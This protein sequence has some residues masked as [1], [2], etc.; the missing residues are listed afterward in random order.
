MERGQQ[1]MLINEESCYDGKVV[2]SKRYKAYD[3]ESGKDASVLESRMVC[4]R[5]NKCQPHEKEKI[6]SS[7]SSPNNHFTTKDLE[8]NKRERQKIRGTNQEFSRDDK[9]LKRAKG[10]R[11]RRLSV[12]GIGVGKKSPVKSIFKMGRS[13]VNE[14]ST[15]SRTNEFDSKGERGS[16]QFLGFPGQ[17]VSYPPGFDDFKEFCKA[18]GVI[19]GVKSTVERKKSLLVEVSENK[20]ELELVLGELGLSRKMRVESMPKEVANAQSI[21]SM[22]GDD[23]GPRQTSGD[24]VRTK[25]PRSGS[26]AQPNLTTSKIAHKFSKRQIKKV[27]LAS[28]TTVSG[29]VAQGKRRRVE[30]LGGL[31]G[32]VAEV[33]PISGDDLI[34]VE[35]R[36][37]LAILHGKEDTNHMVIRLVKGIWLGIEEQKSELKKAKNEL[38][39]NLA[40]AKTDALKEE[41]VNAIKADTYAEEEEEEADVLGVVDGLD[42]VSPQTVLDNQGDNVELLL[43]GSEKVVKEMSLRINNL[44]SGLAREIETSKALLSTQAELQVEEKDSGINKGLENLSEATEHAENLQRLVDALTVKRMCDGLN[45]KVA[46]L[47][48]KRDQAIARSKK[49]EA[50]ERSGGT[51]T[52]INASLVQGD[53]VSLSSLIRE[54]ESDVSRIQGHAQRRNTNLR[55]YPHKLDAALIWEI[56]LEG[57]IKAKDLLVKRKNDLLKDLLAR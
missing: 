7:S 46:R 29:E 15:S 13:S 19:G 48:A 10:S 38:E 36:A 39:K 5:V 42:G 2:L 16:E 1:S 24:E 53:V 35:E 31:G 12:R 32:K 26:S 23:E 25:T 45:E 41:E 54:L 44:E 8:S 27:L 40:R 37:R 47:K 56:I 51:K 18:K 30:P 17:L 3:M 57:E 49:V 43:D 4:E 34:E 20:T 33:Q 11:S 52:V 9:Q 55:E 14:V 21:R 6:N 28:G 50:R 22:M